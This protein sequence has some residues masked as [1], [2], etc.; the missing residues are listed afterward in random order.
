M[1]G[2]VMSFKFGEKPENLYGEDVWACVVD[3]AG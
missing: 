2:A 3:E 1:N